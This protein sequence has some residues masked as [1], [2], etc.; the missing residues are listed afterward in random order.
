MTASTVSL[1]Y[2]TRARQL[3]YKTTIPVATN[4][5]IPEGTIVCCLPGTDKYA[6]I[7]AD[8]SGFVFM[9]IARGEIGD[10]GDVNNNPGANGAKNVVVECGHVQWFPGTFTVPG[11]W[12]EVL[13][14]ATAAIHSG[15][16]NHVAIGM[17]T[18]LETIGGVAGAWVLTQ[19]GVLIGA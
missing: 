11:V 16:T 1:G 5:A 15:T 13:D 12:A 14:N 18:E 8:T 10:G 17:V 19:R 2:P 7:G 9:G 6:R 4:I 3:I